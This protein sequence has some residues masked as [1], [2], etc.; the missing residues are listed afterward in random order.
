M[1][2]TPVRTGLRIFSLAAAAALAWPAAAQQPSPASPSPG[3][4]A[5]AGAAQVRQI[6]DEYLAALIQNFPGTQEALGSGP[7]PDRWS[8]NSLGFLASWSREQDGYLAR[9]RAVDA[10]GLFGQPEWL[11]HGML[12]ESLEG[13]AA[14][15]A[16]R[17]EL[18]GEVDQ[19]F[20]WHIGVSQQAGMA[21]VAT[22]AD[23][24]RTLARWR[25]LP[26][27]VR[28]EMDNLR[29]GLAAGY[30]APRDNVLRVIEQVQGMIAGFRGGVAVLGA[31]H[32]AS[33]R[34][35]GTRGRWPPSSATTCT[36]PC[37][38]YLAFLQADY[39]PHARTD[40]G[41]WSMPGRRGLLPRRHPPQHLAGRGAGGAGAH[42]PRGADGAGARSCFR[43]PRRRRARRSWARRASGCART[44]RSRSARA[45]PSWPPPARRSTPCAR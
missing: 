23:R 41:L 14:T 17:F 18:W 16:C 40:P 24:A 43:W 7:A 27:F 10:D 9:L 39:L 11:I 21:R 8:D 6:A 26:R 22:D 19:I 28:V 20:G 32:A 13:A 35:G 2:A 31:D 45:R 5:S 15:R 42:G 34:P 25:D 3:T 4:P 30:A 36:P 33:E 37:A 1:N 29:A 38:A 44:R 12:R